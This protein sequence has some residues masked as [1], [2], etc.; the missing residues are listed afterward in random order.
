MLLSM[1]Y[2]STEVQKNSDHLT[3]DLMKPFFSSTSISSNTVRVPSMAD[4]IM[5]SWWIHPGQCHEKNTQK[6][7]NYSLIIVS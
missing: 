7:H 3:L 6:V 2:K 5:Y 1:G 4:E